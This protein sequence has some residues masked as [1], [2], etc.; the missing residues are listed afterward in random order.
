MK[1]KF[2]MLIKIEDAIQVVIKRFI[3]FV[4]EIG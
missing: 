3:V 2:L 1:L 4:K